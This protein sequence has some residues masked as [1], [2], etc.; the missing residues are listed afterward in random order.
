MAHSEGFRSRPKVAL[1]TA[2][3]LGAEAEAL[4]VLATL[5][6]S[7][8]AS[9]LQGR[10]QHA[11][12]Q[13]LALRALRICSVDERRRLLKVLCETWGVTVQF[14]RPASRE[15]LERL[16]EPAAYAPR[17]CLRGD[18]RIPLAGSVRLLKVCWLS[19][20]GAE[21]LMQVSILRGSGPSPSAAGVVEAALR[22]YQPEVVHI[23]LLALTRGGV[24]Q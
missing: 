12:P 10:L 4:V 22:E 19:A 16:C 7:P 17:S 15:S 18:K 5:R 21:A 13:G 1:L 11:L 2:L 14:A 20:S 9:S 6:E 8:L 3:P 23:T 24:K